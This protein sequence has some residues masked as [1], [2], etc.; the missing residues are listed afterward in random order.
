MTDVGE[1][2]TEVGSGECGAVTSLRRVDTTQALQLTGSKENSRKKEQKTKGC[3]SE[4]EHKKCDGNG[5]PSCKALSRGACSAL[6]ASDPGSR[7]LW[8]SLTRFSN[9]PHPPTPP[10]PASGAAGRER[11]GVSPTV[12][13]GCQA[14]LRA[15]AGAWLGLLV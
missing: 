11:E 1:A 3:F 12:R 14:W 9:P 6:G 5:R 13:L 15:E 10:S 4:E 7:S 2:E 8:A